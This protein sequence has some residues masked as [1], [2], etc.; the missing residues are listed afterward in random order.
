MKVK[1]VSSK[2]VIN[3]KT[4]SN[5]NDGQMT[6]VK[7][8]TGIPTDTRTWHTYTRACF[9]YEDVPCAC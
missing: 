6:D 7:G 2:L 1:T 4:I 9:Y 8:G 5:L 3:K